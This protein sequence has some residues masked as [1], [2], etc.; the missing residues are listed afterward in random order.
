MHNIKLLNNYV[1][2]VEEILE[3]ISDSSKKYVVIKKS[4][5]ED[6]QNKIKDANLTGVGFDS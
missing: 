6:E 5:S 4:L 1:T 3:K 2:N